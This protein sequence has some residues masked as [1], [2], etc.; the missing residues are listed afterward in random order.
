MSAYL[1]RVLRPIQRREVELLERE[2]EC[3]KQEKESFATVLHEEKAYLE[4]Q[5]RNAQV[6]AGIPPDLTLRP[7]PI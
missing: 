1:V 6:T 3:V 2:L 7:Q 5:L 4:M